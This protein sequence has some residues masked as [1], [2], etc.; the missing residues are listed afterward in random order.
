MT[1]LQPISVITGRVIAKRDYNEFFFTGSQGK[2]GYPL[3]RPCSI[4]R[5]N[6]VLV[7]CNKPHSLLTCL[8]QVRG[9]NREDGLFPAASRVRGRAQGRNVIE[10]KVKPDGDR[11]QAT[12][13]VDRQADELLTAGHALLQ[14]LPGQR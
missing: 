3:I 9:K 7:T 5:S 12:G 4:I 1:A 10:M 6:T 14:A 13:T 11:I 2:R 8:C